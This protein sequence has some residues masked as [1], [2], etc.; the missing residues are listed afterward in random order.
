MH[1]MVDDPTSLSPKL[2]LFGGYG[3]ELEYMIVDRASLTARPIS[4]QILRDP[5][6][7]VA[8]EIEGEGTC[9]SNELVM[10]VLEIKSRGPTASLLS[11]K[12]LFE[13]DIG[14]INKQLSLNH[15]M[16]LPTG[17]HPFFLPDQETK[18]WTHEQNEIYDAYHRIFNCRGHGW[19]NLQSMHINLPFADNEEFGKLHAA[20]RLVLPLLPALAASSPL[21]EG[22][23]QGSLDQRL[24]FYQKNQRV[25]PQ[26]AGE[27]VP[28]AVFSIADY[29]ERVLKPMFRA[30]S[31]HD[32]QGILQHEWLNSRG[33][34]AR[35]ERNAIEIRLIDTQE[36]PKMDLAIASAVVSLVKSLVEERWLSYS[37][38]KLWSPTPLYEIFKSATKDGD[39]T[40]IDNIAYL[41][42]FDPDAKSPVSAMQ[43]WR[44]IVHKLNRWGG[45][46]LVDFENELK[47]ILDRGCLG[48]RILKSL[49][50]LSGREIKKNQKFK[51][52]HIQKVYFALSRSLARGESFDPDQ[53]SS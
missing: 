32:P 2:G 24:E 37:Q 8:N 5:Q 3:I 14:R 9:W 16:L 25:I 44:H 30:V 22:E 39:Q 12:R 7:Q 35:F 46:P 23:F 33:A 10:H 38:Q 15:C 1:V 45:Y 36:C 26:I 47:F 28:E 13:R 20:I 42:I 53:F 18:L 17:M 11:L 6:G 52:D 49:Q 41:R 51:V 40:L 50:F 21:C 48:R 34:I 43:L 29:E 4:D 19:S 31:S 27:V